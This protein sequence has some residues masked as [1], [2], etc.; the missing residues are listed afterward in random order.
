MNPFEMDPIE[1]NPFETNPFGTNGRDRPRVIVVGLDGGTF[2]LLKPLMDA[3]RMPHLAGLLAKG[4]W[5]ALA[6]TIPPVTAPAWASFATG[7]N[8]G[9]HGVFDFQVRAPGQK[10]RTLVSGRDVRG[11]K[12]WQRLGERGLRTGLINLPLT[13]PPEPLSGFVVS[14]ML[15]PGP[16]SAFTYPAELRQTVFQV[17]PSYVTDVDLLTSEWRYHDLSSLRSLIERLDQALEQRRLLAQHLAREQAWDV[18]VYV[19]TELDRV[20]HLLYKLL[21]DDTVTGSWADLRQHAME[22]YERADRSI[23]DLAEIAGE[24]T[25]WF[26]VSDHGFGPLDKRLNLNAWLASQ[27]WLKFA[28]GTSTLRKVGKWAVKT[29]GL[30]RLIPEKW[31]QSARQ[32]LSAYACID[33]GATSAYSGTSLEQGIRINLKGREPRG[34]VEP[35]A[36]YEELCTQIAQALLQIVDPEHGR[37]IVDRVYRRDELYRGPEAARA[38]DLVFSLGDYRCI[39]SEGLPDQPLFAPFPFPWA[40]YHTP[41]GVFGASGPLIEPLGEVQGVHI[42]DLAP[43]LLHLFGAPIP[44]ELDGRVL[45]ELLNP[46]WL[47]AHPVEVQAAAEEPVSVPRAGTYDPDDEARLKDRLRSLGY[48]E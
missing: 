8:P 32:E 5:G 39:L 36:Q 19:I 22:L 26:V 29:S 13:Y 40:G 11:P 15:T 35:G 48:I 24:D 27:G 16:E 44:G 45:G 42:A 7:T 43:T 33:W 4:T 1:T 3:G 21:A 25:T 2:S 23:G 14:G 31:R 28:G 9:K 30:D 6:S 18:L 10:E 46:G 17:A 37:P 34:T 12:F 38:P 41:Q 47:A 20:Q